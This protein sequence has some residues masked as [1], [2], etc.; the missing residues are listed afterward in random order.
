M[1]YFSTRGGESVAGAEA[2]LKGIAADGGL[3]VP[4]AF[5][6]YLP[7]GLAG[8]AYRRLARDI[9]TLYLDDYTAEEIETVVAG[10]YR[11]DNFPD[12]EA[13]CVTLP[14]GV[15]VLELTHGPTSAFKDMALQALPWLMSAARRKQRQE[16]DIVILVATSGDTGKAALEGFKD[17]PG[18][19]IVVFYPAGGV[20]RI[21]ELQ[22]V[23]TGGG[24]TYVL[25]L[26]GNF[27]DCQT[28]VKAIFAGEQFAN[29]SSANSINWGRLLPQIVYYYHAYA[30]M[31]AKGRIALGDPIDICVPT[32]NFGNILAGWYASKMGLPVGRFICASNCN[33]VLTDALNRGHYD[34]RR[35]LHKTASPSMDILISSN[36]ER[37]LYDISGRDSAH[38]ASLLAEL[39]ARGGYR[40]PAAHR[41]VYADKMAAGYTD[42]DAAFA[43]IKR[44]FDQQGYVLDPH[45]A[46]GYTVA[47]HLGHDHPLLLVSTA[48]PY[49]FP[50]AVL[51]ALGVDIAGRQELELPALLRDLSGLPIPVNL[52]ALADLPVRHRAVVGQA[53][54][55]DAVRRIVQNA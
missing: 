22:M 34:R 16:R 38:T 27:D 23:T 24:N 29:F 25:G 30:R 8:Y 3:F 31:L 49:K 42:D 41:A 28:G 36:F 48:S 32:G 26:K 53:E 54:M 45:T 7:D 10:A 12:G 47:E 2:I 14:N 21:Q 50:A 40:I 5:P 52:A 13:P 18:I 9:F 17:V 6:H 11:A 46:V 55:A 4:E 15:E 43:V 35:D 39:C 20:S 19:K 51:G 37:F 44:V 1:R 33:N